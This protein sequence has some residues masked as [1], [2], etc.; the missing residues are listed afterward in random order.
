MPDTISQRHEVTQDDR[1]ASDELVNAKGKKAV[2]SKEILSGQCD[3]GITVQAFAAH[4]AASEARLL[5]KMVSADLRDDIEAAIVSKSIDII[6]G[7]GIP[8]MGNVLTQYADAAFT[9][10]AA[11]LKEQENG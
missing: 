8:D 3:S 4:R 10:I 7:E 1:I 6:R 2:S 11:K 5:A 9:A